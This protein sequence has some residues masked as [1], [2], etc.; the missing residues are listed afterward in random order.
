MRQPI[1][2]KLSVHGHATTNSESNFDSQPQTSDRSGAM[3]L[4]QILPNSRFHAGDDVRFHGVCEKPS[5]VSPG[6]LVVYRIGEVDPARLVAD[7][8]ARGAAGILTEQVL[9]CPLPQCIV[10]ELDLA[11]ASVFSSL[12]DRPDQKLL[13]IGV[14]GSAGKTTTSLLIA[15]LF[16]SQ[17]IRT[18]FQTDLGSSD[19]V[20]Q[21][22]EDSNLPSARELVDWMSDAVD[23]ESQVA[24]VELRDDDARH[25]RYDCVQFDMIIVTGSTL[26]NDDFGPSSLSCVLDRLTPEGIVVAPVDDTR[27]MRVIGDAGVRSF[28]YGVRKSA[29]IT[30]KMIEQADGMSTLLVSHE[31]ESAVMETSLCGGAMAANHAAA[32]AV[33]LLVDW[34]LYEICEL[35]G[36]LRVV[37]GRQDRISRYGH[38][39]VTIDLAGNSDRCSAA[40]RTARAMKAGGRLWCITAI[41]ATQD[42]LSLARL[43]GLLER[44]ADHAIVTSMPDQKKSFLTASHAVLDGVKEC[45]AMR[46]V[47]DSTRALQWAMAEAKPADTILVMLNEPSLTA[48]QARTKIEAIK[49]MVETAW[50]EKE[51]SDPRPKLKV[52][53]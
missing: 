18:A 9:P 47:A 31:D 34:P 2:G 28:T 10:G 25:G 24:V 39:S 12:R 1:S 51:A 6:E 53:G 48:H 41:D 15:N 32:I 3:S 14:V 49:K 23:C 46:L 52:F 8:L 43:G 30:A 44:F 45:A 26:N 13:T 38:A 29:D 35:L 50:D 11:M 19:G 33:G 27:A 42:S 37:P 7:A 17:K 5:E 4:R 20:L 22:T 16:R 36:K 21:S 40:M